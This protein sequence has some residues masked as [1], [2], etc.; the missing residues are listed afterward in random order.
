MHFALEYQL[1]P[2]YLERRVP[3]RDEH[4]ALGR[5]AAARGEIVLAGAFDPP[6][7][8]LLVFQGADDA[9]AR[10]FAES[11]PYVREGLVTSWRVRRWRTVIGTDASTRLDGHG[12]PPSSREEATRARLVTFLKCARFWTVSSVSESGAPASAVVGVAVGDDLSLVFD[13]LGTT[14]KAANLRRDGRVSLTM[15]SGAATAQI[16]GR[17][18]E[19]TAAARDA[20]KAIYFATFTD[21]REREGWADITWFTIRPTWMRFSDFGGDAPTVVELDEDAIADL[22]T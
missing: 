8:A 22:P 5:A 17:A 21:G 9:A 12:A 11:D 19:P 13:T 7:G 6:D 14:R 20:A 16:E 10:R 3:L 2:D 4:L 1:V 18:T 15:W